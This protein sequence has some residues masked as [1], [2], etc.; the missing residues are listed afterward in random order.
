[1]AEVLPFPIARRRDFIRKQA[2]HAARM[3]P[4]AAVRYV[5]RQLLAQRDS[6]RRRGIAET[7]IDRELHGMTAAMYAE[8]LQAKSVMGGA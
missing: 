5:E 2:T 6:M 8:F 3:N 1:M 4:D 7:L